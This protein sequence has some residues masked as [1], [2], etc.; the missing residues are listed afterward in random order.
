MKKAFT[1][2]E[3]LVVIGIIGILA[4]TL[5]VAFSGSADKARTIKCATNM[6]NLA[7]A[8]SSYA[9]SGYYPFAQS[10]QYYDFNNTQQGL[11]V[12]YY[13]HKGWISYLDQDTQYPL[14][15]PGAFSQC[16]LSSQNDGEKIYALSNGAI[17]RAVGG[18]RDCYMCPAFKEACRKRGVPRPGWSYHMN[19][20]FGYEKESGK[21][22]STPNDGVKSTSL[23]RADR[24]LLF[25]EIQGLQLTAKMTAQSGVSALPTVEL[26]ADNGSEETDCCLRY[27][28]V[29]GSESIG[30]NH[31]RGRQIV[32]HVA[33]ADGHVETVAAPKDGGFVDL[34]DWLCRGIDV[35]FREGSYDKINTAETE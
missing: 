32:G 26:T 16:S 17:W 22:L 21:A 9:I 29:G 34:T 5:L 35:V 2:L 20:R 12:A 10:A 3:M 30:F 13:V 1:L 6:K 7:A 15:N 4:G 14:S 8:V 18:N 11:G 28:Q 19:A 25:A 27:K 33:F 31:R 24:T 23:V